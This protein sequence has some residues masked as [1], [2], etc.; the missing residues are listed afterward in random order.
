M[1]V[2][3]VDTQSKVMAVV[4]VT[5]DSEVGLVVNAGV[6]HSQTLMPTIDKVLGDNGL[7]IEDID[8]YAVDVGPGSFTGIRIGVNTVNALAYAT[9]KRVVEF[10]AFDFINWEKFEEFCKLISGR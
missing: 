10:D 6:T 2:L 5:E 1:R 8:A 4:I 9:S 3:A 7:S